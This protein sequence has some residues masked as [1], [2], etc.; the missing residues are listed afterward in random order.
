MG[1]APLPAQPGEV[2]WL[3]MPWSPHPGKSHLCTMRTHTRRPMW[4]CSR[5]E[6]SRT[7]NGT[8]THS[9]RDGDDD[10]Q[11]TGFPSECYKQ[12]H[13]YEISP[14]CQTEEPPQHGAHP[15]AVWGT[16]PQSLCTG[17]WWVLNPEK[18]LPLDLRM[19]SPTEL[20]GVSSFNIFCLL[21]FPFWDPNMGSHILASK[22]AFMS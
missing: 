10:K 3:S 5:G 7:R 15:W 12:R 18:M 21:L 1:Q 19:A 22:Q 14:G 4:G 20:P 8:C 6:A 2:T 9:V 16:F 11:G 13:G 17:V